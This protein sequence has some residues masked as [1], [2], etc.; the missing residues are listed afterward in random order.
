MSE[1]TRRSFL[2]VA[3]LGTAAAVAVTVAPGVS[4]AAAPEDDTT[5][6]GAN[7]DMAAYVYDVNKG[8]V[9]LMVEG[10]EVLVTDKVLVSRL[11][12]AF[13]KASQS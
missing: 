1:S 12:R 10:R 8:Q 11:A 7:G 13:A 6:A 2:A 5:P 3:G 9:A 4:A